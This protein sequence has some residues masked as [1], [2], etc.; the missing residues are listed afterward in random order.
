[1]M[2]SLSLL[3]AKSNKLLISKPERTTSPFGT[4]PLRCCGQAGGLIVDDVAD[5]RKILVGRDREEAE[6]EAE[7]HEVA[8]QRQ[9]NH[10]IGAFFLMKPG[11]NRHARQKNAHPGERDERDAEKQTDEPTRI[12]IDPIH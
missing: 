2:F 12:I 5:I 7:E 11:M 3:G 8:R 10:F 1:M 6:Q 9:A 4:M